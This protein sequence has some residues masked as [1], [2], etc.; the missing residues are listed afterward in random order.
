MV[1][2]LERVLYN[3]DRITTPTWV[4]GRP[5]GAR[6]MDTSVLVTGGVSQ[7]PS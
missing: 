7:R 5:T 2:G 4:H 3:F 6:S 1:K